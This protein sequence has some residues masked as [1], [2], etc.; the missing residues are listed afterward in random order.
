MFLSN[1][2][3]DITDI[4]TLPS[5]QNHNRNV[6]PTQP[7]SIQPTTTTTTTTN[8]HSTHGNPNDNNNHHLPTHLLQQQ[9]QQHFRDTLN[10][11][12]RL[13][14]NESP[15]NVVDHPTTH[16]SNDSISTSSSSSSSTTSSS[17]HSHPV[18]Q[19]H[20][21]QSPVV[22]TYQQ[23]QQQQQQQFPHHS[24]QQV[25]HFNS[26][27]QFH[28]AMQHK[29]HRDEEAEYKEQC[30]REILSYPS[31]C[32]ERNMVINHL[33]A[34]LVQQLQHRIQHDTRVIQEYKK[35]NNVLTS[36]DHSNKSNHDEDK[37][38]E[39]SL[40]TPSLND[41]IVAKR[42]L[43]L[44]RNYLPQLV[45]VILKS[46]PP[47]NV[48]RE[49]MTTVFQ[50]E[51]TMVMQ[52]SSSITTTTSV[53]PISQLRHIVLSQCVHDASIGI[54][55]C[56]L[57]E[58]EVG[59]AWK[60]LFEH[61]QKQNGRRLIIVMPADKA[62]VLAK[63]GMEKREAFDL[64]QDV[65]Q[66][67]AFG[68]TESFMTMDDNHPLPEPSPI[69]EMEQHPASPLPSSLS[70]R[71]CSH[72]GDTMHFIDRLSKISSDLRMIPAQYR[73]NVLHDNLHE[74]N[75]R[76]R[77]RM[78]SRGDISLDVDDHRS[79]YDW[80]HIEDMSIDLISYSVHLP[81]IPQV[82][83]WCDGDTNNP[84][85]NGRLNIPPHQQIPNTEVVR[86]LNIVV[87]EAKLLSSRERCPFLIHVEVA[88]SGLEG[89]DARLYTTGISD[90][91]STIREALGMMSAT[92]KKASSSSSSSSSSSATT[93]D[94]NQMTSNTPPNFVP[95]NIPEELV[96]T[97][98]KPTTGTTTNNT[99]TGTSDGLAINHFSDE[100]TEH[101]A[102]LRG[103][104]QNESPYFH[105][106]YSGEFMI[107][108]F[109]LVRQ[110]EYEQLHHH[111][112]S[113]RSFESISSMIP[114]AVQK[115]SV[116]SE[117]LDNV[118]GK[119]WRNKCREI[120]DAS[121]YGHV[122]GWRL[123]SFIMKA[124]E[125]IRRE[126]F[127][128]QIISKLQAWFM[129]DIPE[130]DRP[131]MRPYTIMCVGGDAGLLECLSDAKSVDEVKKRT[132]GFTTLRDY[133]ERA[134]GPPRRPA[135]IPRSEMHNEYDKRNVVHPFGIPKTA[136]LNVGPISFE[137]AQDNFLRSLVGYSLVCYILQIK[138]RHNANILL[139]RLGHIMHIDF[140]YVLGDT[141]KMGKVPIFSERAPFKLSND[142]WDVLGG[143]N[144]AAG[145]LGV[146]FCK[147]FE[148]A[149]QCASS[150]ADEIAALTEAA[151]LALHSNPR[152]A[153]SLANGV[154]SRLR[155]R[156]AP[157]SRE[158]K[159]FIMEL[160]NAALTSWGTSTYDWLQRN[161]NGYQ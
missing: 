19:S 58:A 93:F 100:Q 65:E 98:P 68:Y 87:H 144:I 47:L 79:P 50:E 128:M 147:M 106:V 26:S 120:R 38:H 72:F 39:S 114:H 107:D 53:N 115:V 105:D 86:V 157:A 116:G 119:E 55:L 44:F 5:I 70:V 155:M 28:R 23:Q 102:Y 125:D 135:F 85:G 130:V 16:N 20:E 74:L 136:N 29:T 94:Q 75:R 109:D 8:I 4:Q 141:P 18:K 69:F 54:E 45:A 140:G 48:G 126:S 46:P 42:S 160:V 14:S 122:K 110:Q 153:R 1:L 77:R 13:P 149:F 17:F 67:T 99:A 134:Y 97:S 113:Q 3:R 103:G 35:R 27:P 124:G 76:L 151:V 131:F 81:L 2:C 146:K 89:N 62:M 12:N 150:H 36:T 51:E 21:R 11:N 84:N 133:F 161:M 33:R 7:P 63:I 129:E 142:F 15:P 83:E 30:W 112:H 43:M 158:Q 57:L 104:S 41:Y 9:Q 152:H 108:P 10:S 66:A 91:G 101:N 96:P 52:T 60:T 148:L 127:V 95:Y 32:L 56:W 139:D 121:P 25:P 6:L 80:P 111:L 88:D 143:W 123:A 132:D 138:D 37:N 92:S 78:V 40:Q 159:L 61:R 64:L 22:H 117:L 59:R 82:R 118:F 145:G 31:N 49:T 24:Q 90:I 73:Y 71:R 156:G 154:R 34:D 137:T